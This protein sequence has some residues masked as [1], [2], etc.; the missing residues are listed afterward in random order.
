MT[1]TP[2]KNTDSKTAALIGTKT[3]NTH[4]FTLPDDKA[5]VVL[6][7]PIKQDRHKSMGL[8]EK[9]K[10]AEDFSLDRIVLRTPIVRDR[11]AVSKMPGVAANHILFEFQLV[12]RVTEMPE[13]ILELLTTGD[14][15]NV[16]EAWGK[17]TD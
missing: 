16:Q 5:L 9:E 10:L 12:V 13:E 1:T 11:L 2:T 6:K 4:I 8:I 17:L 7:K 15:E 3:D 14:W